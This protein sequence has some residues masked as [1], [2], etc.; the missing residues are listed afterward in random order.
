MK[1]VVANGNADRRKFLQSIATFYAQELNIS[2]S[3]FELE[4]H[5]VKGLSIKDKLNGVVAV[6]EPKKIKMLLDSGL[7]LDVLFNTMAHEM[8]HVKQ[9]CRGQVK[10]YKKRNGATQAM[11]LGKKYENYDYYDLP[12]EIEAYSREL[13]LAN[14]LHKILNQSL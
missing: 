7:K 5:I 8:V 2:N 13:I 6:V 12:W 14:K 9:M 11:W 1:I 4:I 3:K 10:F